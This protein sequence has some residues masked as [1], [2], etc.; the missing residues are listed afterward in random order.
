MKRLINRIAQSIITAADLVAKLTEHQAAPS[1]PERIDNH[2]SD[3][4]KGPKQQPP[5]PIHQE[6]HIFIN[7]SEHHCI[8]G[9]TENTHSSGNKNENK[10]EHQASRGDIEAPLAEKSELLK[11]N[12][13]HV[14]DITT[15]P[16][17]N[18]DN[19]EANNVQ[20][21]AIQDIESGDGNFEQLL[22]S[23][24]SNGSPIQENFQVAS[25]NKT[26]AGSQF[27]GFDISL[28]DLKKKSESTWQEAPQ[29]NHDSTIQ[30]ENNPPGFPLNEE[31]VEEIERPEEFLEFDLDL[32]D[33][34]FRQQSTWQ[35]PPKEAPTEKTN[36]PPTKTGIDD[37]EEPK[38][39]IDSRAIS[40]SQRSSTLRPS[41]Q[42]GT[43]RPHEPLDDYSPFHTIKLRP[44]GLQELKLRQSGTL[45]WDPCWDPEDYIW[46]LDGVGYFDNIWNIEGF[47]ESMVGEAEDRHFEALSWFEYEDD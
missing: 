16:T 23:H 42:S 1:P 25:N 46:A 31:P 11:P 27:T 45:A 20:S 13:S 5:E 7:F 28:L 35:R 33:L 15:S 14:T 2:K 24:P 10:D 8:E 47:F 29:A 22:P 43:A 9:Q 34:Q 26:T 38:H 17:H 30:S 32:A 12:T 41:I 19:A 21:S 6:A 40:I 36:T 3:P 44:D 39:R 18:D 4:T 37:I